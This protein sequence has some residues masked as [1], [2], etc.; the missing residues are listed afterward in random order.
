MGWHKMET[1]AIH[2]SRVDSNS[3]NNHEGVGWGTVTVP[4]VHASRTH[5]SPAPP[6]VGGVGA[7]GM[8]GCSHCRPLRTTTTSVHSVQR[9]E[10]KEEK[11]GDM[12][13][14]SP[15]VSHS[16]SVTG[17]ETGV[18]HERQRNG[19]RDRRESE[20]R[21][22]YLALTLAVHIGVRRR[23]LPVNYQPT[24][25]QQS[26]GCPLGTAQEELTVSRQYS[27]RETQLLADTFSTDMRE[28][29]K[30]LLNTK[31]VLLLAV[32]VLL[33]LT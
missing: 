19:W 4:A 21:R 5:R 10:N 14:A 26:V 31:H 11:T 32:N 2:P 1:A 22:H 16:R 3:S 7:G 25:C 12:D 13:S 17:V 23:V 15:E 24:A 9:W 28:P 29:Q 18:V 6:G 20:S 33:G 8:Q 30:L 27:G